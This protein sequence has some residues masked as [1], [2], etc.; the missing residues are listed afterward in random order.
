MDRPILPLGKI[1]SDSFQMLFQSWTWFFLV[2]ALVALVSTAVSGGNGLWGPFVISTI[3]GTV[4]TVLVT[5]AALALHRG[6]ALSPALLT[7]RFVP[8]YLVLLAY[9]AVTLAAFALVGYGLF[10]TLFPTPSAELMAVGQAFWA[11]FNATPD[12]Q[13]TLTLA[14]E[15]AIA[16]ADPAEL[17]SAFGSALLIF[18]FWVLVSLIFIAFFTPFTAL[19]V[20]EDL[21]L[22]AVRRSID[23]SAGYGLKIVG[24]FVVLMLLVG[25]GL[26]VLGIFFALALAALP[27]EFAPFVGAAIFAPLGSLLLIALAQIYLQLKGIKEGM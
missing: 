21:A 2:P 27:A 16:A 13:E 4:S 1:I 23:L 6:Q 9:Q 12:Q 22:A 11:L 18:G 17:A 5:A 19:V 20:G 10:S 8:R 14:F 26:F 25:A 15:A 24:I 7:H 3:V